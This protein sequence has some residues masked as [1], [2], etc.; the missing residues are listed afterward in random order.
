MLLTTENENELILNYETRNKEFR[1]RRREF[2]TRRISKK[3]FSGNTE[4]G[5]SIYSELKTSYSL[6]KE[7]PWDELF[8]DK[9]W[10]MFHQ[11]GVKKLSSGR[12]LK[13]SYG[14][15]AHETQQ[16]DVLAIDDGVAFVIECKRSPS[17]G[18]TKGG[19]KKDIEAMV[20]RKDGI[21][22][23]LRKIYGRGLQ[24][25]FI[26][27]TEGYQISMPDQQRLEDERIYHFSESETK[28]YEMLISQLGTAARYQLFADIFPNREIDELDNR[29]YALEGKMGGHTYYT[30]NVE[31]EKLLRISYVLH[32]SKVQSESPNYQRVIKRN[33]LKKIQS[34]VNDG[35]YFPNSLI[36]NLSNK[37]K[38]KFEPTELTLPSSSNR[39]GVLHLPK[40]LRSAY[41][42]DG[43]HR[44]YGYSDSNFSNNNTIPVVA[45]V[46][47]ERQ[48]QLQIFVDINEN[49]KAV[50]ANLRL[51]LEEDL[52]AS[53]DI[54]EEKVRGLR[55]SIISKLGEDKTSP[56]FDRV[57]LGEDPKTETR[58]ISLMSMIQGLNRSKLLPEYKKNSLVRAGVFENHD[59]KAS[60]DKI[61][62]ILNHSLNY[63]QDKAQKEWETKQ[64]E[65]GL[66][67]VPNGINALLSILGD[68]IYYL[69]ETKSISSKSSIEEIGNSLEK[70]IDT[71]ADFFKG[72]PFDQ[73]QKLASEKGGGAPV[74]I[75]NTI[76]MA[77]KDQFSDFNPEGLESFI[78]QQD[79]QFNDET[80]KMCS[81]LEKEFRQRIRDT[82][83]SE[84]GRN[85]WKL[86]GI[87]VLI[88]DKLVKKHTDELRE[89]KVKEEDSEAWNYTD[90]SDLRT[91][92]HEK[93]ALFEKDFM[94]P[95]SGNTSKAKKTEWMVKLKD[96]RNPIAHNRSN[97]SEQDYQFVKAIEEWQ[98]NDNSAPIIELYSTR[99]IEL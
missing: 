79:S 25:G 87:P 27:A 31:P 85:E 4:D 36:I 5:W 68:L 76:R 32:R 6:R 20:R 97:A 12:N 16:I 24:V 22:N 58:V 56:L 75:Q 14:K 80:M 34:F 57:L 9:I 45:F 72:L 10:L 98:L 17:A 70:Y 55:A 53:S 91:I 38:L 83:S 64:S 60:S 35:G 63:L 74:K 73:R 48:E 7:K 67:T 77:I 95:A 39:A 54:Q 42:I 21:R 8:E 88:W 41:I 61:Y 28:Y 29:V 86:K 26:F 30:F 69:L 66:I 19:F 59:L 3:E 90:F 89:G 65:K 18:M 2:I 1:E 82:L 50:P 62:K 44:L 51:S 78:E 99:L 11:M 40:Q 43:Q 46:G 13:V 94:L 23:E 52:F 96:I 15:K 71:I 49:Q 81:N 47:L 92:I 33:R 93:W 37:K 84:L